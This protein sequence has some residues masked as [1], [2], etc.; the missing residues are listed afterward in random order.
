MFKPL[1]LAGFVIVSTLITGMSAAEPP[2]PP[3][4]RIDNVVDTH[5]GVEVQDPYRYME[6][7][8]DPYVR[9]WF[10]GQAEFAEAV[11]GGLPGRDDLLDRLRELDAGK[12][13]RSYSVRRLDDGTI[14]Y[15][16]RRAGE[17]LGKLYRVDPESGAERLLVDPEAMGDDGDQHYSLETYVP[18]PDGRYVVYG[19]AQGG[20]EETVY[21]TLD[22]RSG[23][24]VGQSIDRIETAYNRPHWHPNGS[25]FFYS[26]RQA[27]PADA[28]VTEIY[29]KS[30]LR[31][32]E[33]GTDPESD[34]VLAGYGLSERMVI[35]EVDFP[36]IFL[37]AGSDHAIV[38]IRHGDSNELTLY[39]A[40]VES[41]LDEDVPWQK[42]CDVADAVSVF[43]VH[44]DD[45]YLLTADGAPRLRIVRTDL[46]APDFDKAD[47]VLPASDRVVARIYGA[48]DAIYAEV[49]EDGINR[50]MRISY[51][52]APEAALLKLPGY[53]AGY[54]SSVSPSLDGAD[55]YATSWIR[56]SRVYRYDPDAKT[57]EDTGF[58]PEGRFDNEPGY[59]A[60]E[61][62][63]ESH[64]GVMVPLS[65]IHRSDLEL[66]GN[67]PT[68]L[69]GYGS[70]SISMEVYFSALRLAWLER[71]GIYAVAH[72][73]GGGE[74]GQEW[75]YAGRMLNKP[76]TWKD[77]IAC[78]EYLIEEGY[79]S[80][81]RLAGQGGS[82]GGILIGRA[83]TERPDLFSAAVMDVPST[84]GIRMETTTNGVP[85]I[86]EFG[87]VKE[88][89]G[90]RGLLAM[91]SYHHVEDDTAYPAVLLKHGFNDPRVEPWMSGKMAARLQ[92]ATASDRPV[93]MRIDFGSGHGI[94]STREQVLTEVAD[95]YAFLF[96]QLAP[97]D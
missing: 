3:V 58:L 79:T 46:S 40:P 90:F 92:A 25:G 50:V 67:N 4:A 75:H 7:V 34:P 1:K 96:W 78:A 26:R 84:D 70:Y 47:V 12:P 28:P 48:R 53:T 80:T 17:N 41:L 6:D 77:F 57:L 56:G 32:H 16:K 35:S 11:L 8:G 71:G 5:W 30:T 23:K 33:L 61:V 18:S 22:L 9:E 51:G 29:K 93:L 60:R 14:F 91:S 19:I 27:L 85:N 20:S 86:Q 31:F 87:T 15:L 89:D 76:N 21:H 82:A 64:D 74:Y 65:I 83:I 88:Q 69:S 37:T 73:R 52:E 54:V 94:G 59:T 68:L 43:V 38:K 81:P 42:I 49:L 66:D 97:A 36:S 72:V 63:V 45:I 10:R 24:H 39:T 55:I 2:S 95:T 62:M 44:G 13:Y